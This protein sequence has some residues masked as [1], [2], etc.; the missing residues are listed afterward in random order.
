MNFQEMLVALSLAFKS[1]YYHLGSFPELIIENVL[2][3]ETSVICV[4]VC[5]C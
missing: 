2:I 1:I 3:I 5:P 4:Y